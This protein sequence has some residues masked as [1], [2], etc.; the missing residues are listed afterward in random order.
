VCLNQSLSGPKLA[1]F[2]TGSLRH[3][4]LRLK[5]ELGLAVSTVHMDVHPRLLAGEEVEAETTFSEDCR[6][7]VAGDYRMQAN[8]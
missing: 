7:H 1:L 3:F 6:A 4:N 8:A 5:P 2:H